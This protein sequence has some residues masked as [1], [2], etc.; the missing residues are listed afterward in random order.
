MDWE[1]DIAP[2]VLLAATDEEELLKEDHLLGVDPQISP[3]K[4]S[5]RRRLT[6]KPKKRTREVLPDEVY[7]PDPKARG[8]SVP[9]HCELDST[10]PDNDDAWTD[11]DQL[12]TGPWTDENQP[13]EPLVPP[14][15][16]DH[17][18]EFADGVSMGSIGFYQI[19]KS[20]FVCEGWD[21]ARSSTNGHWYHVQSVEGETN[22]FVCTCPT[23]P[24]CVHDRYMSGEGTEAFSDDSDDRDDSLCNVVI[25]SRELTPTEETITLFS[26]AAPGRESLLKARAIVTNQG[27]A[28]SPGTWVCSKDLGESSC[29]HI[30]RAKKYLRVMQ[31]EPELGADH[32]HEPPDLGLDHVRSVKVANAVSHLPILPPIWAALPG[33]EALYPRSHALSPPALFPLGGNARCSCGALADDREPITLS[34]TVYTLVQAFPASISVQ[35]C[36]KCSTGRRRY[37]GPDCRELGFFNY[38]NRTLFSHALLDDYTS[39][40]TS[41]ETPFVA[42]VSVVVRRYLTMQSDPFVSAN[43]FRAAW[44]LFSRL[45][46]LKNDM[47]CPDCGTHPEDTIWDGVTLGFSRKQLLA[48]L[49]PPTTIFNEAP[50]HSSTYV[51]KQTFLIEPDLRKAVRNVVGGPVKLRTPK[52]AEPSVEGMDTDEEDEESLNT[53]AEKKAGDEL[54]ERLLLIPDVCSRLSEVD[55]H[56]G[57]LF[58]KHFGVHAIQADVRIPKVY[59]DLFRQLAAEE[60]VLQ[61]ISVAATVKLV[62][63]RED[64]TD[65]TRAQLLCV[66][67]LFN[68]LKHESATGYKELLGVIDWMAQRVFDVMSRLITNEKTL[69][70]PGQV[71][72]DPWEESGCYY[73]MKA[74]RLRPKYPQLKH[75]QVAEGSK[76]GATCSKFYGQYGQQRLTGG[77][78]CVWCTHSICYGFHCIPQGEGRNDVFSAIVTR[79]PKAPK[80]VIYDF[81]CAL[82]PYCMTRE[83][84]FFSETQFVIDDFHA[85]GHK[86]CS[87]AAFLKTYAQVDPRLAR[88]NTSA[89]ECGNGG[90]SRIRKGVS[91]M[92]QS[93]A[94][95]FTQVFIS[96]WNR[97]IIG[98]RLQGRQ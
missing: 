45:Q 74:I 57:T 55:H 56:L 84:T 62:Q 9:S 87:P 97:V 65:K 3:A 76:R 6:G 42:W 1:D 54:R 93:R 16:A 82:G 81:A 64:P 83:P 2:I 61:M 59:V 37:I 33:D 25:F 71:L 34:C 73:S 21:K 51:R 60:S 70:S 39:A 28:G 11:D 94:I 63:F 15:E 78:M 7:E 98:K 95:M 91:Y 29:S 72:E 14:Q 5:K 19:S 58:K 27:N 66:P 4:P 24:N 18:G 30:F 96:I 92:G 77:I 22:V 80:R 79:W 75:D 41:S 12:R 13:M 10:A 68:V 26:V 32:D 36:H 44:F 85:S 46:A 90:I 23:Q 35:M 69:E 53:L 38:N 20:L 86:K 31:G 67:A 43:V 50:T 89:A 17:F 52:S 40:F 48:S 88:I 49:C 8:S 47:Q